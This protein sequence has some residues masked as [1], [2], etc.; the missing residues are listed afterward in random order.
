MKITYLGTG[1]A[2]GIPALFCTCDGCE[3]ARKLGGK[4]IRSRSQSLINK[5]LLIDFPADTFLHTLHNQLVLDD[6]HSVLITHTHSDHFYLDDLIQKNETTNNNPLHI[7][8]G[9]AASDT[10]QRSNLLLNGKVLF[11]MLHAYNKLA[12][13]NG[14]KVTPLI[15][16]HSSKEQCFIYIIEK[17]NKSILYAHDTGYFPQETWEYLA[18]TSIKFDIVSL[19]CNQVNRKEKMETHM[20]ITENLL[21]IEKLRFLKQID[22]NTVFVLNH[23]SHKVELIHDEIQKLVDKYELT[24]AYDGLEV[25]C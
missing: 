25:R 10:I 17:D 8:G 23:I 18:R 7:Y 19:D 13:E 11:T 14:Y 3:T 20:G 1:S 12:L 22:E 15:A 16:S 2:E 6:V 24:V 9:L 5:D 21:V 4:N